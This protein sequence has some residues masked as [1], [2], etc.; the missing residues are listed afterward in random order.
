[1]ERPLHITDRNRM[2]GLTLLEVLISLIVIACAIILS[3]SYLKSTYRN[4]DQ[5]RCLSN[6]RSIGQAL[7]A[8]TVD[9]NGRLPGPGYYGQ[10]A[11]HHPSQKSYI[12][13]HLVRYLGRPVSTT[14]Q[15]TKIPEFRCPAWEKRLPEEAAK[16]S[17]VC[18]SVPERII[19]G[20]ERLV[21]PF[22]NHRATPDIIGPSMLNNIPQPLSTAWALTHYS[23]LKPYQL[24]GRH[25]LYLFFDGHVEAII[26]PTSSYNPNIQ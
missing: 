7:F 1:M 20:T 8:Y 10:L 22:G 24:H 21:A 25:E 9:H 6:L 17:S 26:P 16:D 4:V 12:N 11:N 19:R 18:Y 23:T 13:W 2:R 14:N 15:W 3:L 5:I